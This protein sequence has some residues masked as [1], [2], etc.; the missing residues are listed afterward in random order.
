MINLNIFLNV[1]TKKHPGASN[2][3]YVLR[4]LPFTTM[5]YVSLRSPTFTKSSHHHRQP[6]AVATSVIVRVV[7][8]KKKKLPTGRA[9]AAPG[10]QKKN[11]INEIKSIYILSN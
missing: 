3:T 10:R 7:G 2:T 8:K 11:I 1:K 6:T 5:A 9:H 4:T